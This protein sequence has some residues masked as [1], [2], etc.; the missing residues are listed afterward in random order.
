MEGG[1]HGGGSQGHGP[2]AEDNQPQEHEVQEE[3]LS[4]RPQVGQPV[5][6]HPV[7]DDVGTVLRQFA[8]DLRSTAFAGGW[9]QHPGLLSSEGVL[10]S[11]SS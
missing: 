4:H 2:A 5:D 8:Q 11:G 10:R 1:Q 9:G 7:D 3:E 6:G